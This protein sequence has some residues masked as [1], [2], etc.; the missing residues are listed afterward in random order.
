FQSGLLESSP[1]TR[2]EQDGDL[3]IAVIHDVLF[4]FRYDASD[5]STVSLCVGPRFMV[6]ARPRPVRSLDKLRAEVKG[7]AKFNS[8]AELLAP[9][10]ADQ[11]NVMVDIVRQTTLRVDDIEDNVLRNRISTSRAELSTLRR[12]LVRLQRVLAPEPS[13]L[14]R[15]LSRP[16]EWIGESDL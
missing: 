14:F 15:L 9:L 3:L 5:V 7:D 1:G 16:P 6:S 8:P 10:L 13:T 2:I 4:D 12:V 11:A